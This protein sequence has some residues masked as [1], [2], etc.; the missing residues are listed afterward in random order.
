MRGID[1]GVLVNYFTA[2]NAK[3]FAAAEDAIERARADNEKIMVQCLVL[4]ELADVLAARCKLARGEVADMLDRLMHLDLFEIENRDQGLRALERYRSGAARLADYLAGETGR[5]LG[6]RDTI[7]FDDRLAGERGFTV[8][9]S[10][11]QK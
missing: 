5:R 8:L 9:K 10:S 3:K 7:T 1:T 11:V 2:S 6:C 4:C